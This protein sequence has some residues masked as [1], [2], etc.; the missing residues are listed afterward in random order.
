MSHDDDATRYTVM[1]GKPW[2][3]DTTPEQETKTMSRIDRN[4]IKTLFIAICIA[5]LLGT[6]AACAQ[7]TEAYDNVTGTDIAERC[8]IRTKWLARYN[9]AKSIKATTPAMD[10]T[11]DTYKAFV[12][13]VCKS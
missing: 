5:A 4:T 7:L 10:L 12:S 8:D 13:N 3:Y 6:L 9:V 2:P 11:A 1:M